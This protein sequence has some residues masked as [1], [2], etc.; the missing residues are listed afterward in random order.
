M[1]HN[2]Y[3]K[4]L[5]IIEVL[6]LIKQLPIDS[7]IEEIDKLISDA[8]HK[9]AQEQISEVLS[10]IAKTHQDKPSIANRETSI[11]TCEGRITFS[12]PYNP[13]IMLPL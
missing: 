12:Y 2:I 13:Q 10:A 11:L 7:S 4:C 8:Y 9:D 6:N 5:N 3:F 1:I